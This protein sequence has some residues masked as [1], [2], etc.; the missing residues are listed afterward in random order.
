M[1]E[2]LSRSSLLLLLL[3]DLV[4]QA[5]E[6]AS[7]SCSAFLS[8]QVLLLA[9]LSL[10]LLSTKLSSIKLNIIGYLRFYKARSNSRP[11]LPMTACICSSDRALSSALCSL[12]LNPPIPNPSAPPALVGSAP[13]AAGGVAAPAADPA[14]AV[15]A[16]TM[17]PTMPSTTLVATP[18]ALVKSA[19]PL[20]T[21][22]A[23]AGGRTAVAAA[24]P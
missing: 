4:A 21:I 17:P 24:A 7:D 3:S 6:L 10:A 22:L 20:V 23:I 13:A 15:G 2:L 14:A 18:T 5:S 8:T 1:W 16:P 12:F 19:A 11:Y 9:L